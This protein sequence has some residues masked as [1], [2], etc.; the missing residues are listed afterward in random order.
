MEGAMGPEEG[1]SRREVLKALGAAAAGAVAV[2][3]LNV[4]EAEAGHGI[5]NASSDSD[6]PAIHAEHTNG[7]IPN[8]VAIEAKADSDY[9]TAIRVTSA[10]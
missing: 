6:R 2:G 10:S 4:E 5:I 8:G 7:E 1:K 3:V 9:G